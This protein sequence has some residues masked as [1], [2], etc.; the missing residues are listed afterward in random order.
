MWGVSSKR[1]PQCNL[2]AGASSIEIRRHVGHRGMKCWFF[3]FV[4]AWPFVGHHKTAIEGSCF[5]GAASYSPPHTQCMAP[6]RSRRHVCVN[7]CIICLHSVAA[8]SHISAIQA[9][10]NIALTTSAV[11]HNQPTPTALTAT[12]NSKQPTYATETSKRVIQVTFEG[13]A[14][15]VDQSGMIAAFATRKPRVQIPLGPLLRPLAPI[16]SRLKR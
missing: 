13:K 5:F 3:V 8:N 16:L 10:T 9:G 15:P 6:C 2:S 11:S 7:P 14:G 1:V 12:H 4:W